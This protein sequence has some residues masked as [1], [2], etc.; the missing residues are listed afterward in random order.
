[1]LTPTLQILPHGCK[2]TRIG[3]PNTYNI[4]IA[5]RRPPLHVQRGDAHINTHAAIDTCGS[6]S[7]RGGG[8]CVWPVSSLLGWYPDKLAPQLAACSGQRIPSSG[9]FHTYFKWP[10]VFVWHRPHGAA[11]DESPRLMPMPLAP[12][13]PQLLFPYQPSSPRSHAVLAGTCQATSE[14]QKLFSASRTCPDVGRRRPASVG[15]PQSLVGGL[16]TFGAGGAPLGEDEQGLVSD[17]G[18]GSLRVK[19][20]L[21]LWNIA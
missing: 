3:N 1:M 7:V 16:A 17:L 12:T 11:C 6:S 9:A 10:F 21:Q 20:T 14:S 5:V 19:V 8:P 18:P 4:G 2:L 15:C 13:A